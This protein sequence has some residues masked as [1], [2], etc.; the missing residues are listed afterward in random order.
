MILPRVAIIDY[1]GGD[2]DD[3]DVGDDDG[4]VGLLPYLPSTIILT[5]FMG[6]PTSVSG[7]KFAY[8]NCLNDLPSLSYLGDLVYHWL[9]I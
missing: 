3:G 6:L 7:V 1:D 8:L 4:D 5:S 2:D 9:V